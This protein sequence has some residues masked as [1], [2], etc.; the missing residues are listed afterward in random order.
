MTETFEVELAAIDGEIAAFSARRA[1]TLGA[2]EKDIADARQRADTARKQWLRAIEKADP[3]HG[4]A[5][6]QAIDATE[7]VFSLER[8]LARLEPQFERELQALQLKRAERIRA[9]ADALGIPDDE[10][11]RIAELERV[12]DAAQAVLNAALAEREEIERAADLPPLKE[13]SDEL[14]KVF[15]DLRREYEAR[16]AFPPHAAGFVC[17]PQ[18]RDAVQKYRD[19]TREVLARLNRA[20]HEYSAAAG[21]YITAKSRYDL[22]PVHARVTALQKSFDAASDA[23]WQARQ[24]A[25]KTHR[26]RQAEILRLM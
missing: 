7:K 22:D 15:N 9:A 17:H 1:E 25:E 2:Q 26:N 11:A 20:S 16:G 3:A 24:A 21:E 5:A 10:L 12:A 6:Q 23:A 8:D 14:C 19:E 18:L 4:V 13:R